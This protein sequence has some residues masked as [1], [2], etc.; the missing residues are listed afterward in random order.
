MT[1]DRMGQYVEKELTDK[2]VTVTARML[3][4]RMDSNLIRIALA[5]PKL[6]LAYEAVKDAVMKRLKVGNT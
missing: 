1:R 3:R 6:G 5:D 4:P 2:I